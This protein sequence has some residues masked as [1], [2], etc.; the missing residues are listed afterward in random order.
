LNNL[1]TWNS[2][3]NYSLED[4]IKNSEW[5]IFNNAAQVWNHTFYW[6]CLSKNS[7]WNP[8][9]K[10]S[11]IIDRDFE[12]FENFKEKFTASALTNFWS[13]WTWLSLNKDLKLEIINTSNAQTLVWT[14]N[15]PLLVIDIWEHAYYIDVRNNRAKYVENF[16][17]LV[18]WDFVNENLKNS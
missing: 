16:W 10:I 13:W 6:N 18:N 3:E 8:N 9:W 15:I 17:N 2:F 11:E 12:N 4:V 1:V 7:W 5:W 14:D